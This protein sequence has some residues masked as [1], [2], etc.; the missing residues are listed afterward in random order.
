MDF[1]ENDNKQLRDV[2]WKYVFCGLKFVPGEGSQTGKRAHDDAS[3]SGNS[4]NEVNASSPQDKRRRGLNKETPEFGKSH[5]RTDLTVESGYPW[6]IIKQMG[7]DVGTNNTD[8]SRAIWWKCVNV[9]VK[10]EI[11]QL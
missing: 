11:Q 6:D 2:V 4:K 5:E 10:H 9:T 7:M 3:A 1:S 8:Y